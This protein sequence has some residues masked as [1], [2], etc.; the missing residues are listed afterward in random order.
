MTNLYKCYGSCEDNTAGTIFKGE[1]QVIAHEHAYHG[2]AR[3]CWT[4]KAVEA[5]ERETER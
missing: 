3:T 4:D 1:A 2:G 5:F